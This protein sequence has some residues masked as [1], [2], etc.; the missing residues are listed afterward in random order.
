VAPPAVAISIRISLSHQF[1]I[2]RRILSISVV[3]EV[4]QAEAYWRQDTHE[5]RDHADETIQSAR[6]KWHAVRGLVQRREQRYLQHS[7]PGHRREQPDAAPSREDTRHGKRDEA[8]MNREPAHAERVGAPRE[9]LQG[10]S[11]NWQ[12]QH[13]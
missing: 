3:S 6:A 13:G 2:T 9:M 1:R 11:W 12:R 4:D 8:R 5:T 7:Q 10:R